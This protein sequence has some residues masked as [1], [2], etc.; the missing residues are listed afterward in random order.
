MSNTYTAPPLVP[1]V[2]QQSHTEKLTA[3]QVDEAKEMGIKGMTVK[4]TQYEL[5]KLVKFQK[6]RKRVTDKLTRRLRKQH[7][8]KKARLILNKIK[9][10]KT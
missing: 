9:N 2:Q 3:A 8:S 1:S 4:N 7:G 5:L 10:A 6:E